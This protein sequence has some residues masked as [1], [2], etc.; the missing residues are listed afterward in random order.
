MEDKLNKTIELLLELKPA[1]VEN[2][3]VVRAVGNAVGRMITG[4][5]G[6]DQW[7]EEERNKNGEN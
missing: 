6:V 5:S 4:N 1:I 3:V 2:R 7:I